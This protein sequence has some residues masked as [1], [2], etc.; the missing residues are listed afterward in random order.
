VVGGLNR[1]STSFT[2]TGI[3]ILGDIPILEYLF[4]N[5]TNNSQNTTLFVFL[6][7]VILRD[8]RFEDLKSLSERDLK[9]AGL[10]SNFPASEPLEMK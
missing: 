7:P 3:P 9:P 6:R 1:K 5:R 4:S 8:D 2:K 10:P